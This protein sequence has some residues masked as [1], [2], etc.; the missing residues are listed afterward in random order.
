MVVVGDSGHGTSAPGISAVQC[1]GT[2]H[3]ALRAAATAT[4]LGL[5]ATPRSAATNGTRKPTVQQDSLRGECTE[6]Q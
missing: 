5:N 6:A 3:D 1:T 4:R 2:P